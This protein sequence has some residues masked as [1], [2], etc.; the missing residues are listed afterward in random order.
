MRSASRL[1]VRPFAKSTLQE[2]RAQLIV[3]FNAQRYLPPQV[4]VS[5]LFGLVIRDPVVGLQHQRGRQQTRRH[6]W[7]PVIAAIQSSKVLVAEQLIPLRRQESIEVL[8]CPRSPQTSCP[9]QTAH[10]APTADR[11]SAHAPFRSSFVLACSATLSHHP[12]TPEALRQ[13]SA[14]FQG[15]LCRC[16][17]R[18]RATSPSPVCQTGSGCRS[19]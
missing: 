14:T 4:I 17:H 13:A 9:P 16:R 18:T 11:A 12:Y 3:Q 10:A 2:V 8:A 5:A 6:A 19:T 15:G 1:Y 7:P